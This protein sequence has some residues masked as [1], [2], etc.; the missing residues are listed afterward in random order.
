[1]S[2]PTRRFTNRVENYVK[3]RPGYPKE[4]LELFCDE[5]GLT[6]ASVVA[7]VGSGTGISARV[8]LENGNTVY[9][10]EP[11]DAM[12]AGAE[13][14]L[15]D[16]PNFRSVNGRSDATGL[17]ADSVDLV[18]AAQAFHWF[19]LEPTRVEFQRILRTLGSIALIWN[20]RQLDSNA[21]LAEYEQFLLKHASDYRNVRHENTG[22]D[23]LYEFF[24][25]DFSSRK[26]RNSQVLDFE[27]LKGRVV[28]SSYMPAEGDMGYEPMIEELRSL[29]AKHQERGKIEILYDTNVH[30]YR[31]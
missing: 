7:D 9:G 6:P 10:V 15:K 28:S 14:F 12:R 13:E 3:Y 8:F 11:N 17:A 22:H 29:F 5:M 19:D 30:Y 2:D 1:M 20:E 4:M 24:G 31:V 21:F 16:Y 26:F 27:G 18:I 23:E 25:G